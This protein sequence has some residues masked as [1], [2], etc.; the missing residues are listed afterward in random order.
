MGFPLN[1]ND[2]YI[3]STGERSTLG[4][5]IGAGGSVGT[6]TP[7]YENGILVC[8]ESGDYEYYI[9]MQKNYIGS[10]S[11]GYRF[12]TKSTSSGAAKIDIST[13][14][15]DG[16][17]KDEVLV[18]TLTHNG[19]NTYSDDVISVSYAN[20]KWSVSSTNALYKTDGTTYDNP[21]Q[22][23]YS[24]D[25]DYVALTTAYTPSET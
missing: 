4:A 1:S 24:L 20:S 2:P 3:K 5:E 9:T 8:G 21:L 15:Y 14:V 11:V 10:G 25:V 16:S 19:L 13:L 18:A 6:V 22:W 17:V 7:D 23:T 12:K